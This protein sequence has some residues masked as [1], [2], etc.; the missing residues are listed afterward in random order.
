MTILRGSIEQLSSDS[1]SDYDTV[2]SGEED[3]IVTASIDK[4]RS[5]AMHHSRFVTAP[6]DGVLAQYS[7]GLNKI[8]SWSLEELRCRLTGN[9]ALSLN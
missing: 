1:G 9:L 2:S 7:L 8:A 3:P 5:E 4:T 6:I